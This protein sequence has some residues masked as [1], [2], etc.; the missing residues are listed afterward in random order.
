LIIIEVIA[1][2]IPKK[3]TVPLLIL[4]RTTISGKFVLASVGKRSPTICTNSKAIIFLSS[5]I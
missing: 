1:D 4:V 5:S 3:P 2:I